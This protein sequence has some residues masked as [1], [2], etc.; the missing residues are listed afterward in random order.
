MDK[1]AVST[2]TEVKQNVQTY[3]LS[4]LPHLPAILTLP[5]AVPS[6]SVESGFNVIMFGFSSLMV[7]QLP[8][9]VKYSP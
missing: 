8:A 1:L 3:V 5:Y 7:M 9:D 6:S 2:P 4:E